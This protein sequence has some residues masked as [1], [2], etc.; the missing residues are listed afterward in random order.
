MLD[1]FRSLL[2]VEPLGVAMPG[3]RLSQRISSI[4][5]TRPL[6][7]IS[8]F[9]AAIVIAACAAF[10]AAFA[11]G[12]LVR[13]QQGASDQP[14]SATTAIANSSLRFDVASLKER[15]RNE[16]VT[17][18][19]M[20]V[21]PGRMISLCATLQSLIWYAYNI[22]WARP[23][24]IPDWGHAQCNVD[25]SPK[26]TYDFE[27]TMP[28]STTHEQTREMLRN[29]LAERFKL[30]AHWEKRELPVYSLVIAP[31]GFK[32][33]PTEHTAAPPKPGPG[34]PPEDQACH[35]MLLGSVP[36]SQI[37]GILSN[38]LGR[39]VVDNTGLTEMYFF[40]LKWAGDMSPDSPL[41]SLPAMLREQYGLELKST[42]APASLLV[43]DHAEKPTPN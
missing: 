34:C 30:S 9:R 38:V 42:T 14:A 24:G 43:I 28:A 7:R 32:L 37:T 36:L 2:R 23:E 21:L 1:K 10:S 12:T 40:D 13:A 39:P 26:N 3:L 11:S 33:K 41:P 20:Q 35:R 31:G 17:R 8:G 22:D 25:A 27:A 16:P 19:G 18:I 6:S 15:D 29:F 4:I 5:E